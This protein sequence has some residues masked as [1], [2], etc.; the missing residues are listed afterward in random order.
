MLLLHVLQFVDEQDQC[1]AIGLRRAP[2]GFQQR[3]QVVLQV[4]I[5]GQPRLGIEVDANLDI[6]VLQLER[7]GEARQ[8]AQGTPT[9]IARLLRPRQPQQGLAQLRCQNCRQRAAFGGFHAQGVQPGAFGVLAHP[10]QQHGLANPAQPDHQ[11]ALG[12]PPG[13]GALTGDVHRPQQLIAA[14][15][16]WRRGTGARCVGIG[17]RVHG[18]N[19]QLVY[20]SYKFSLISLN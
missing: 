11:H 4:A 3:L 18:D 2:G 9:Q 20:L 1:G 15:Q 5:V 8:R 7:L 14:G 16:L 19:L 6:L 12:V 13:P 17:D 10:V